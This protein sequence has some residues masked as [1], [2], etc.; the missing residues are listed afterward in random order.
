[1]RIYDGGVLLG[2]TQADAQGR[3]YF[4]PPVALAIGKHTLRTTIVGANG[5]EVAGGIL[6]LTV[7][8]GATGLKPL[9][10]VPST[11]KA[12][13]PIGL[14]QGV[15]PPDTLVNLYEGDALLARLLADERGRRQYALPARTTPGRHSYRIVVT[16]R[17]GVK[18]YQSDLIPIT[19][20][21]GPPRVLPVTGT[22]T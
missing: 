1:M 20:S 7:A 12:P 4:V 21:Y 13:S 18:L 2:E 19:I 17:D 15:A 10:F 11:G 8:E 9:T 6:E 16:T 22:W 5:Q 14:L 3:W